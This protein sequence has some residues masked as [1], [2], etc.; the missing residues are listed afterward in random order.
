MPDLFKQEF[1]EVSSSLYLLPWPAGAGRAGGGAGRDAGTA[2][3]AA[4]V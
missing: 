2:A 3:A 4:A 1:L